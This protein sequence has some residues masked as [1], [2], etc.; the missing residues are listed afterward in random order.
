[1]EEIMEVYSEQKLEA[2]SIIRCKRV[3]IEG[4]EYGQLVLLKNAVKYFSLI[5][6]PDME[7]IEF[8]YNEIKYMNR[9]RYM[10]EEKAI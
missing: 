7:Q 8:T 4:S 2:N 9:Y 10:F 1:M 5:N 6:C 3:K